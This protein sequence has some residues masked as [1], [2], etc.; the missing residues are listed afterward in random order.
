L[1]VNLLFLEQETVLDDLN[2]GGDNG[3]YLKINSVELIEA[4]PESCLDKSRED[5][6]HSDVIEGLSTIGDDASKGKTLGQILDCLCLSRTGW[7]SWGSSKLEGKCG[8]KGHN[9]SISKWGDN[10]SSIESLILIAV[11]KLTCALS[12]IDVILLEL[13]VE[14]EL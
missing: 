10:Q 9:T 3:K 6:T 2:L 12:D 8:S 14:S 7:T 1:E 11:V 5:D 4:T 13:P